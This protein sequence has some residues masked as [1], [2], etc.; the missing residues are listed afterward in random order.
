M[1]CIRRARQMEYTEDEDQETQVDDENDDGESWMYT[2]SSRGNIN[3]QKNT[4]ILTNTF[5]FC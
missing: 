2:H 3:N 1:P 5:F 4:V